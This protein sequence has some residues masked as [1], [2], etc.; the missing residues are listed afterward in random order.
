MKKITIF[1]DGN[2]SLAFVGKQIKEEESENWSCFI[3]NF[4]S[5]YTINKKYIVAIVIE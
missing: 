5:K 4:D 1:L 2:P 3:D